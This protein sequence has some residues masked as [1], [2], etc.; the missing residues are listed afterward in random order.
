MEGEFK[1]PR[2]VKNAVS[3]GG[4]TLDNQSVSNSYVERTI[5]CKYS[6]WTAIAITN[7]YVST[8]T[9]SGANVTATHWQAFY[10]DDDDVA[11]IAVCRH[12]SGSAK[13]KYQIT[14]MYYRCGDFDYN[15]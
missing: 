4:F 9:S 12:S 11:H 2:G 6:G 10:L 15:P 14:V 8:A 5:D 1:K 7:H 3:W 13:V